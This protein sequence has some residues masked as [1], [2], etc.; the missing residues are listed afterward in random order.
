MSD[1]KLSEVGNISI[2]FG[3]RLSIYGYRNQGYSKLFP[4]CLNTESNTLKN[5]SYGA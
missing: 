2:R 5:T 1:N 3:I 4:N